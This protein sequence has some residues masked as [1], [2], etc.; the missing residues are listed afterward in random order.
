M[1]GRKPTTPADLISH[2]TVDPHPTLQNLDNLFLLWI[3]R[4]LRGTGHPSTTH[5]GSNGELIDFVSGDMRREQQGQ[6]VYR[7][8]RLLALVTGSELLPTQEHWTIKVRVY[9]H[10]KPYSC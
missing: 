8:E 3:S 1:A 7:A 6:K 4:Y 2:I 9:N 10:T 5:Q